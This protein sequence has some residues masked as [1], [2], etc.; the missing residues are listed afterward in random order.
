MEPGTLS[1]PPS[2]YS[3]QPP[4]RAQA[5]LRKPEGRGATGRFSAASASDFRWDFNFLGKCHCS[6][7]A[8]GLCCVADDSRDSERGDRQGKR[9]LL[10]PTFVRFNELFIGAT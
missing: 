2:S 6:A 1:T 4:L 5:G 8:W 3:P 7:P 10:L 9:K